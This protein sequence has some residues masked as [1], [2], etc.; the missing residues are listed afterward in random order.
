MSKTV[1][2]LGVNGLLGNTILK[3]FV[4]Q[5][6]Y[7]VIGTVRDKAKK[8]Y[9]HFKYRRHILIHKNIIDFRSI[10]N[11]LNKIKPQ[12]VI[13][14]IGI[15]K[16][17]TNI[18]DSK[19][20]F[21]VNS[22]LPHLLAFLTYQIGARL[23]HIST[24]CVFSGDKGLYTEKDLPDAEDIYGVS[25]FLGE[26]SYEN[27]TI[28]RT[29]IIGHEM[30]TNSSLI[31]WFLSQKGKVDGY[32]KAIFS[33]LPTNELAKIIHD[34]VIPK[35]NL[36]G[37]F[38]VSSNSISKYDLLTIVAKI[39]NKKIIINKDPRVKIDRSL[40]STKFNYLTGYTPVSWENLIHEM[41][42]FYSNN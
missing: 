23:I 19:N 35:K 16:Q 36:I 27:T 32:S 24:D 17:A 9:F 40:D 29:S 30:K 4:N 13:N 22:Y 38:H 20:V 14:C 26:V 1:L 11:L 28:L 8:E 5:K 37:L 2:I 34:I 15:I 31:N 33:G 6:K 10:N 42:N 21:Y 12:Y 41:H 39:Y 7:K 25:K 18:N 3:F